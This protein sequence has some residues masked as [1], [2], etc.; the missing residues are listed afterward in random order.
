MNRQLQCGYDVEALN[1]CIKRSGMSSA[2]I[3]RDLGYSKTTISKLQNGRYSAGQSAVIKKLVEWLKGHG[4]EDASTILNPFVPSTAPMGLTTSREEVN[5]VLSINILRHYGLKVNPFSAEIPAPKNVWINEHVQA[6]EEAILD[7]ARN[8][9]FLLV[10]GHVGTGKSTILRRALRELDREEKMKICVPSKLF[11]EQFTSGYIADAMISAFGGQ[12]PRRTYRRRA[13]QLREIIERNY[14]DNIKQV[15]VVDEAQGL[16]PNTLK[17]LKRFWE[18]VGGSTALLAVILMGQPSIYGT[19]SAG[20]LEEV[21]LRLSAIDLDPFSSRNGS[22]VD[23]VRHK[24]QA[25]AGDPELFTDAAIAA[26]A[27][28]AKTPLQV[29]RI[30]KAALIEGYRLQEE[31]INDEVIENV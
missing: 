12:E 13:A 31:R 27:K 2:A 8:Q 21:K 5:N 1:R 7:A 16:H 20:N 4:V 22:M 25:A 29:N 30:C 15:L 9:G 10:A 18:G 17:A 11:V 26:I 14:A 19:L 23:Y 6:V 3:A 28:R 24:L